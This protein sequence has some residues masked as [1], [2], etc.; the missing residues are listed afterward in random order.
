[1][2]PQF[3]E[4]VVQLVV[5]EHRSLEDA[6]FQAINELHLSYRSSGFNR[7]HLLAAIND[8]RSLFKPEQVQ[9]IKHLQELAINAM[10]LVEEFQPSLIGDIAEGSSPIPNI[11]ILLDNADSED[12]A[13]I[14]SNRNIPWKSTEQARYINKSEQAQIP[15]ISFFAENTR[16]TFLCLASLGD[17]PKL[18]DNLE[19]KPLKRKNLQD[20]QAS[21]QID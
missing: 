4:L 5:K 8:Y 10:T 13:I 20:M 9:A 6:V 7:E 11:E 16:I 21:L 14:L 1:M 3:I 18:F 2:T 17:R 15:G 12:I 19:R